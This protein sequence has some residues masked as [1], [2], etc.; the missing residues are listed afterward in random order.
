[1]LLVGVR[2][3]AATD[4]PDYSP[5]NSLIILGVLILLSAFFS[6]SE[7]A[8][9]SITVTQTEK[10]AETDDGRSNLL[11]SL[12]ADRRKLLATILG[13]NEIM[14]NLIALTV[15]SI[16]HFSLPG[17]SLLI[18]ML[19]STFSALPILLILGEVT[20]KSLALR[21]P[22]NFAMAMARLLHVAYF[23]MT[24]VR[25]IIMLVTE[26][27]YRY[28]RGKARKAS[29]IGE[30]DF[31]AL[32]EEGRKAGDVE[33]NESEMIENVFDFTDR[34]IK[35]VMAPAKEIVSVSR[36]LSFDQLLAFVKD[37]R[38]SR[39]P[40]Y[41][42]SP[43]VFTGFLHIRDLIPYMGK[44]F[45]ER[46]RWSEEAL[47]DILFVEADEKAHVVLRELRYK[48]VHIALVKS[49]EEVVGL[50]SLEDLLEEVFGEIRDEKESLNIKYR[51]NNHNRKKR[52]KN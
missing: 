36:D 31:R 14:N 28:G 49:G 10:L 12:L 34:T 30:K 1:M 24:P 11:Y 20:P 44:N 50:I 43:G 39:L 26:I 22:M 35:D 8:L 52:K 6:G 38:F 2:A 13:G 5:V 19:I 42:G 37:C 40:V 18:Q 21:N 46:N 48:K 33:E 17:K 29:T 4:A 25:W 16:V 41:D 47:N 51:V 27:P 9:F 32:V 7:A 3:T 23:I 15:A 45:E